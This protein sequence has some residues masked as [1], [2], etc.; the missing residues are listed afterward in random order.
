MSIE[1]VVDACLQETREDRCN[2]HGRLQDA[3][4]F[5]K[6]ACCRVGPSAASRRTDGS[7]QREML[8]LVIPAAE[9]VVKSRPVS[10]FK[11]SNDKPDAQ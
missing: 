2:G 4:S 9:D 6:F 7:R 11:E 1:R 10:G 5:A 8:T 3:V